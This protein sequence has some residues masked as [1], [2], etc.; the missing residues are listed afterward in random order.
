MFEN[1]IKMEAFLKHYK[2]ETQYIV[3]RGL[4]WHPREIS[5]IFHTTQFV[6]YR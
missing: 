4:K 3:P 1:K 6:K 5:E 2:A